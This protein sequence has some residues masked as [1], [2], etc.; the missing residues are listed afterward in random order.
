[1]PD[2]NRSISDD[3]PWGGCRRC[4]HFRPDFTC[5]AYP[6]RIPLL[7]ASG[8]VDHLVVRPAQVGATTFTAGRE[9][10]AQWPLHEAVRN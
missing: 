4:I 7:I 8:D 10:F 1:M 3:Q 6:E 9:P 2:W 5:E